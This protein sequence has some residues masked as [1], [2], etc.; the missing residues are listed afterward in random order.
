MTSVATETGVVLGFG[1]TN[2]RVGV[3]HEGDVES[4]T[5]VATPERPREFFGWMARQVLAAADKGNSW[6]VAGFPGPVSSDGRLA[7]PMTNVPGLAK[8]QYHLA[9]ELAAADPA[10][11][12]LLQ[13]GFILVAV[14][15]GELAAQA[16]ADRIGK[17]GY[18]RTSALIVGTGIG[19]GIVDRDRSY[20]NVCRADRSN[21]TEIG[22]ILLSADPVDTFEN[23]VSGP[24]LARTYGEDARELSPDHP[25]WKKVGEFAGRLAT[26]LGVMNG[27]ELVVLCGGVGAGASDNYGPHLR[28]MIDTYREYGN[29][30]Q[31][32]FL[33]EI[34]PVP[35]A[36][37]QVF[38]MFGGEGVM[39]DFIT[40]SAE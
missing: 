35:Q 39:R 23:A 34:V 25:A 21:P 7:G 1:G 3:C 40:R 31:K 6:L 33:P 5:S 16:A 38:E 32:L 26:I 17:Y 28:S 11:G 37:A 19:A 2:A 9:E 18:N 14:N 24:A 4:F 22:H 10:V 29:G 13:E 36:D 15:D 30:P 12:R 20:N 8:E 27:V